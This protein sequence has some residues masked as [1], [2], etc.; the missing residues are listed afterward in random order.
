[1]VKKG[2]IVSFFVILVIV[3]AII[4]FTIKPLLH[5]VKLGLDLQGGFEVLYEVHAINENGQVSKA[6]PSK[7]TL[8]DAVSTIRHR[9][10]ALGV[11]EPQVTIEGKDHI[12][13]QLAGVKDQAKARK[14][15]S[16]TANLSF[17]DV[18][19]K[20]MMDGSE[21]K[22]G[23]AKV[24]FDQANQPMVTMKLKDANKFAKV[25]KEILDKGAPNN[26]LVIWLDWKKGMTYAKEATKEKPDP[27][28]ISAP[29]VNEV[30]DS[31][32]VQITGNFS[33]DEA[34][35][36]SE[37]LNAGALPVDMKE[38]YST[39]VGAQFG[40]DA[41]YDTVLAGAIG[42]AAI[43]LFMLLFYRFGGFIAAVSL[44]I[45]LWLV[46]AV[47][48]GLQVVLT[49]P[50]IAALILGVG[51]AVDA[52]IITLERIKDEIRT[53]KSILSAYKSGNK[54]SFSTI[55]DANLTTLLAAIVMFVYGTSSV[56]GFAVLL[57]VSIVITFIASVF[58]SR[59]FLS[60]WVKSR[61]LDK[62]PRLF[63]VKE[64]DID[65]L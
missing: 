15:L 6:T 37:L 11:N 25:T 63:G 38:I 9:I 49:L 50:G 36:L 39:S 34:K 27:A 55:L 48:V 56:K 61:V 41:L 53:G 52:N 58:L 64:S 3:A 26:K 45:Y 1:M 40:Q 60:L 17:R 57:I 14:L 21:L 5:N 47:F 46:I 51:M 33:V 42:I 8:Q 4:G 12:R 62:K 24:G 59:L 28:F 65:E 29:S 20:L 10:D 32:D 44:A 18:D 19:N 16:T 54:R 2:R 43:F 35:E 31:K 7:G 22:P 30:I 23:S 13:V